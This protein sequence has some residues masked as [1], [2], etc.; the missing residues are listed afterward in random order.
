MC[1]GHLIYIFYDSLIMFLI[2]ISIKIGLNAFIAGYPS[3]SL[4]QPSWKQDRIYTDGPKHT[5]K[6]YGYVI[7]TELDMIKLVNLESHNKHQMNNY[8]QAYMN[9]NISKGN[10]QVTC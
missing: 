8:F 5:G 9:Y 1:T 10:C 4:C 3:I 6:H 2:C 7:I